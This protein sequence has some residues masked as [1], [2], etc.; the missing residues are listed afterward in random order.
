MTARLM[1]S[2]DGPQ[3]RRIL[4]VCGLTSLLLSFGVLIGSYLRPVTTHDYIQQAKAAVPW[5]RW[6]SAFV[7]IAFILCFFGRK[8]LRG[9]SILFALALMFIW[10][11]L[12]ISLY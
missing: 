4:F 6:G 11:G 12:G 8:W 7:L 9:A 3:A 5:V 1:T 10:Y 2:N